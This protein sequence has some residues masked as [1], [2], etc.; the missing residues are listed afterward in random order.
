VV[1]NYHRRGPVYSPKKQLTSSCIKNPNVR[2]S[3]ACGAL[4]SARKWCLTGSTLLCYLTA[5]TPIHNSLKDMF[6]LFRFLEMPALSAFHIFSEHFLADGAR[7]GT[8]RMQLV[9]RGLMM[10][11]MKDDKIN[12]RPIIVL[13]EKVP[14]LRASNHRPSRKFLSISPLRNVNC[15]MPSRCVH[16]SVS[17]NISANTM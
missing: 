4:M 8:I 5:G 11:R 3:Q 12:G 15:I 9:L 17:I 10:R 6:P 14:P 1:Q 13:P 7:Q 16:A 2:S